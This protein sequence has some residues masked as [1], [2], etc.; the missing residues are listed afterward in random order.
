MMMK[1][2]TNDAISSHQ[3]LMTSLSLLV[4]KRIILEPG[5]L[6][7]FSIFWV[8]DTDNDLSTDQRE[9]PA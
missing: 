3:T 6:S 2:K 4:L 1:M 7:P 8:S 9:R 5:M